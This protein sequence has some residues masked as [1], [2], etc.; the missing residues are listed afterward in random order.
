[1]TTRIKAECGRCGDVRLAPDQVTVRICANDGTADYRYD[2]PWCNTSVVRGATP[3]VVALLGSVGARR[4]V[5]RWP[6]ELAEAKHG[7]PLT[8]DDL[9]D[10]HVALAGDDWFERCSARVR[11]EHA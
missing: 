3:R 4:E 6:A 2:C 1:M 11:G 9:L 7:P 10:F 5:W 8:S